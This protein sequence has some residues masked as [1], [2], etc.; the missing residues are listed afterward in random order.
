M[1]IRRQLGLTL[2]EALIALVISAVLMLLGIP[3]LRGM[4]TVN[5][6]DAAALQ[7]AGVLRYA[8]MQALHSGFSVGVCSPR[9]WSKCAERGPAAN[10]DPDAWIIF[11]DRDGDRTLSAPDEILKQRQWPNPAL[12]IRS[13]RDQPVFFNP[14][15]SAGSNT[16][17]VMCFGATMSGRT[18]ILANSGRLRTIESA[19]LKD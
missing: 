11:L 15:G 7:T 17:L 5:Q 10:Q 12:S 14:L 3:T 9:V 6:L 1:S 8:R 18:L 19:C 4:M 13:S 2:L 16:T